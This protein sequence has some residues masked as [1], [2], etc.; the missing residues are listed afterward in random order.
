MF[1]LQEF[2]ATRDTFE[3]NG[4]QRFRM[5]LL[6]R[7]NNGE[8]KTASIS[9]NEVVNYDIENMKVKLNDKFNL[10][11]TLETRLESDK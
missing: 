1:V 4:A 8:L 3:P 2:D 5:R 9:V 10:V 6:E 7:A 11:K